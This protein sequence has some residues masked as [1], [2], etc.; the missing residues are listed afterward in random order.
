MNLIYKPENNGKNIEEYDCHYITGYTEEELIS[1]TGA[2]VGK[3]NDRIVKITGIYP[4][5]T[6]TISCMEFLMIRM[7]NFEDKMIYNQL[8]KVND[9]RKGVGAK[10][11]ETQVVATTKAG[12][13]K[14]VVFAAGNKDKVNKW[15]GY[16]ALAK[17]GFTMIDEE[18]ELFQEFMRKHQRKEAT[19]NAL[20]ETIEGS[21]FWEENGYPW[22]GTFDLADSSINKKILTDYMNR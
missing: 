4:T 13:S 17:L 3:R 5:V 6:V 22:A 20:V 21:K 2:G 1:F 19:L 8:L 11:I 10:L 14:L 7:M 15:S 16:I 12:F 18:Q 9:K